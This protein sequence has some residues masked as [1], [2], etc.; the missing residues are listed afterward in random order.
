MYKNYLKNKRKNNSLV[1]LHSA[2]N[3]LDNLPRLNYIYI[4]LEYIYFNI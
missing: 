1:D 3:I 2:V 4:N